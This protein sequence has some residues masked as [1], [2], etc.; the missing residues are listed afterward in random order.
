MGIAAVLAK[1]EGEPGAWVTSVV[2][3]CERKITTEISIEPLDTRTLLGN[4]ALGTGDC[5]LV[6]G[7]DV[8]YVCVGKVSS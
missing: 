1:K 5:V 8:G 3:V 2:E 7:T 4:G 6:V